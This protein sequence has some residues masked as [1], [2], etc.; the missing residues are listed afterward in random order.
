VRL[1][2]KS[3]AAAALALAGACS[4]YVPAPLDPI[5]VA[6]RQ[7]GS[8]LVVKTVRTELARLA[9]G[10]QWNGEEWNDLTLFAAAMTINPEI[11]SARARVEAS[12]AESSAARVMQ[13][14]SLTLS[15]EYAF[16]PS[17]ASSWLYGVAGELGALNSGRRNRARAADIAAR[18][19]GFDYAAAV[20]N[21]RMAIRRAMD[22]T[23]VA[24]A[25]LE[26]AIALAEWRRRQYEAMRNR[27]DSGE[28]SRLDLDL[29]RSDLTG[30]LQKRISAAAALQVAKRDLASA[31]GISIA[32]ADGMKFS[33]AERDLPDDWV[34]KDQEVV[35]ALS[36][37]GE[38][39]AAAADYDKSE[40]DLRAAVSAQYPEIRFAP[41]YTWERGLKKLPFA[42]T[43][44]FPSADLNSKAI[45]A[46]ELRRTEAGLR[47]EAAV[48]GVITGVDRA[49]TSYQ[50][51]LKTLEEVRNKILPGARAMAAQADREIQLGEIDRV[52]WA[53]AQAASSSAE[54][55]ALSAE[56][57]A[58]EARAAMEDALRHPLSGPELQVGA[59]Q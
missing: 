39:L 31:I 25:E 51:T 13:G 20:W 26:I 59:V 37:R 44:N 53:A 50:A 8:Q 19:A 4:T 34:L 1:R 2:F 48:A 30:A 38:I 11:A 42:L 58:L 7:K 56:R 54:L 49:E 22:E 55:E 24:G 28:A 33:A 52:E 29:V 3:F 41:G 12:V 17:E 57:A 36:A 16:N 15:A 45:R 18:S 47:L 35:E 32:A 14:P 9:P 5:A 46:A 21:V 40:A 27:V 6:Q 10:Y 43:L 23:Y